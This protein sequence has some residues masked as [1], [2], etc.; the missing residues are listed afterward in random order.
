MKLVEVISTERSSDDVVAA[1]SAF[2]A[3]VL[4]K[5]VVPSPD[6][7][8]FVV[9]ALLVPPADRSAWT[10]ASTAGKKQLQDPQLE[11]A[12]RALHDNSGFLAV[13]P[14]VEFAF[15]PEPLAEFNRLSQ[16]AREFESAAADTSAAMGVSEQAVVAELPIHIRGSHLNLGPPVPREFP[17]VLRRSAVRPVT[18]SCR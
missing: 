13:P 4:G 1:A 12:R 5:R 15:D 6:R 2:V 16:I 7:A 17:A 3:D 9:N 14:K 11:A 8:G 10:Q 18:L